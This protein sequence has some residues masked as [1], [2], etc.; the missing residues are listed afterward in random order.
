MPTRLSRAF[1][2]C[3][4]SA[5]ANQNCS[6]KKWL[7]SEADKTTA[8]LFFYS[9]T[10]WDSFAF[11]CKSQSMD[12]MSAL[13]S[14]AFWG[15]FDSAAVNENSSSM[16]RLQLEAGK[17]AISLFLPSTPIVN[18]VHLF[19]HAD[20]NRRIEVSTL[21]IS[22]SATANQKFSLKKRLQLE[23]DEIAV[24][25]FFSSTRMVNQAHLLEHADPNCNAWYGNI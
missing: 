15:G 25:L 3:L 2:G 14:R 5:A 6:L 24:S 13:P 18:Q 16:S 7:Q 17:T 23:A 11:A 8:S 1:W 4:N 9:H 19:L 22:S 20:L 10:K 21:I 12:R